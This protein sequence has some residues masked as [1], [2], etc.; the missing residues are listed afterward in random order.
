M[1]KFATV[2]LAPEDRL[3]NWQVCAMGEE[4]QPDFFRISNNL[5][6]YSMRYG[7]EL[8]Q[9]ELRVEPAEFFFG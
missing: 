2:E 8:F 9:E 3:Y 7:L 1:R 4:I 5:E 6:A